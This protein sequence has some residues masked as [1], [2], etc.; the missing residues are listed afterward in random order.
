MNSK[1]YFAEKE[2]KPDDILS[3]LSFNASP[4]E[5]RITGVYG[6][7]I[8]SN[9]SEAIYSL[10]NFHS[11][12]RAIVKEDPDDENSKEIEVFEPVDFYVS[13]CGGQATEM[14]G[15]YDIMRSIRDYTPIHT[16]GVG[17]VMS[18][19]VLLLA[20]GT[21]GERRVGAHCRLMIHGVISGQSGHI[22]DMENEF[23]ETKTTQKLYIKALAQETDMTE[24]HIKRLMDQKTNIYL[25]AKEAVKLGIADIIF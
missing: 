13:T 12:G 22:A 8:E 20:A 7:I 14:F 1:K 4:P 3:M 5:L 2:E 25:D 15:V 23:E 10:L 11:S 6:D 18:A 19:G 17:K 16:H 24:K 21:K 9:A